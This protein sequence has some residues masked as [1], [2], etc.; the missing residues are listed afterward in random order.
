MFYDSRSNNLNKCNKNKRLAI[1]VKRIQKNKISWKANKLILKKIQEF[2][3]IQICRPNW[4]FSGIKIV[5]KIN[6]LRSILNN[7]LALIDN[8]DRQVQL[9]SYWRFY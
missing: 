6:I 3:K 8:Y 7:I 2:R 1:S 5:L 4:D 9:E